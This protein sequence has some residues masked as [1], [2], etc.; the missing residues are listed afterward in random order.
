MSG[1]TDRIRIGRA[2]EMLG[3]TIDT[4]RRWADEGRLEVV[5]SGGGQRLVSM[6]EVTR[7]IGERRH[8]S[9]DRPIVAQSARN[10]FSGIV[11]R[12]EKDRVAAVVEIL[13]GPHRL[14]SLMTAEAVDD[15]NLKVGDDAIAVVKAT[16]VMVEV[17][18]G[19]EP[20]S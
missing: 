14:V 7:L 16:N 19:R 1:R 20:R 8:A 17:P 15:M 3:V 12:I 18:A 10:R 13:A 4:V 11:T 6:A 9:A 5:R 2:A